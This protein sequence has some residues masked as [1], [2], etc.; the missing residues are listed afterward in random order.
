MGSALDPRWGRSPFYTTSVDSIVVCGLAPWVWWGLAPAFRFFVRPELGHRWAF[1]QSLA[2]M[3]A[4]PGWDFLFFSAC[5]SP[6]VRFGHSVNVPIRPCLWE[7]PF[8]F[9]Q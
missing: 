5:P 4:L 3:R 7:L 6:L 1:G 8:I 2:V 9:T